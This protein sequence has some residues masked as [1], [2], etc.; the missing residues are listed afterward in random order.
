MRGKEPACR[1]LFPAP[2]PSPHNPPPSLP[3]PS[4]PEERRLQGAE[5]R[6]GLLGTDSSGAP[7][8][9]GEGVQTLP[10]ALCLGGLR[11]RRKVASFP[12][13]TPGAAELASPEGLSSSYLFHQVPLP[14]QSHGIRETTGT[15][16]THPPPLPL[17]PHI[18]CYLVCL[19]VL[20]GSQEDL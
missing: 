19:A 16:I 12:A 8:G 3:F 13:A 5:G 4:A 18:A 14:Q 17:S 2:T 15:R 7:A 20:P 6:P 10:K 11:E 9:S 1:L